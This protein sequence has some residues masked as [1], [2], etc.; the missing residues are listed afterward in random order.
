M[1]ELNARK[2]QNKRGKNSQL[3]QQHGPKLLAKLGFPHQPCQLCQQLWPRLLAKLGFP[4][5][6]VSAL[7]TAS[8]HAVGKTNCCQIIGIGSVNINMHDGIIRT[9]TDVR[10]ISDTSKNLISLC[11][12]DGKGYKYSGGDGVLKVSKGSLIVMRGDLKSANLYR[13]RYYNYR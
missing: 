6:R 13:S 4:P 5:K 11:T 8:A 1:C 2:Q 12:L 3:C 10:H 9:L 7:P